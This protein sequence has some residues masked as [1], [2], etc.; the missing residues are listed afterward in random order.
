M[1]LISKTVYLIAFLMATV[2]LTGC[3]DDVL[4]PCEG[5]N[6]ENIE[7]FSLGFTITLPKEDATR[8]DVENYDNYIDTKDKFRVFFFDEYGRFLFGAIDRTVTPLPTID[9]PTSSNW[10]VRV[11]INYIVDRQG[12][13]F[14]VLKIRDFLRKHPFKVAILANWPNASH[15]IEGDGETDDDGNRLPDVVVDVQ[16]EPL[17]NW[18]NSFLNENATD[19]KNINDLHHLVEDGTYSDSSRRPSYEF[20][21]KYDNS[22][23]KWL[24]SQMIN[25]VENRGSFTGENGAEAFLRK[26]W[27][28][29]GNSNKY[30]HYKDLWYLWCFG[31]NLFDNAF[32]EDTNQAQWKTINSNAF[33]SWRSNGLYNLASFTDKNKL[34]FV[35]VNGAITN[36]SGQPWW[37][38]TINDGIILPPAQGYD[39]NSKQNNQ[40]YINEDPNSSKNPAGYFRFRA[41]SQGYLRIKCAT[42]DNSTATIVIQRG[43]NIETT[44]PV[45]STSAIE[46]KTKINIT[47]DSEDVYIW[48]TDDTSGTAIIYSI[49]YI[50][51]IHLSDTDR[52]NKCPSESN[53]IPMYGVQNFNKLGD[54]WSEGSTFDLSSDAT[55]DN[56]NQY[57]GK[58][59]SLIRSL[60]KVEVFIHNDLIKQ[61]GAIND[62]NGHGHVLM[63]CLNRTGRCEPVDVETPTSDLWKEHNS[64]ATSHCEYFD[65]INYG[66]GYGS[67]LSGSGQPQYSNY[68]SWFYGTWGSAKWNVTGSDTDADGNFKNVKA[69]GWNY[70]NK[71]LSIPKNQPFPHLF[72]PHIN[73]SDFAQFLDAGSEG[74][75]RKF[76]FYMPDKGIDDPNTVGD[77]SKTPKVAHIEFRFNSQDDTNLDDNNCYRIYF[78]S[79][80]QGTA[81]RTVAKDGYNT[82]E[83]NRNNLIK[84]WPVMRNHKYQFYVGGSGTSDL[85]VTSKINEWGYG[86]KKE[87]IW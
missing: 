50:C 61:Y 44:I 54:L 16:D 83:K 77:L 70:N 34:N 56:G 66:P 17:W 57:K 20:M 82:Y 72:N 30:R 87:V 13:E 86:G 84:H 12:N 27:V 24:G 21:L 60:A 85:T 23:G 67:S 81:I 26:N 38:P 31:G 2:C 4:Q 3:V 42:S 74:N 14:D 15:T 28:P 35:T 32:T 52:I 36:F 63:R 47:E 25:W 29:H 68:L 59:I 41:P 33:D 45:T 76:V 51:N 64:S 55:G 8:S 73:R 65:I 5:D 40:K 18:E 62:G 79:Y 71:S 6:T 49:E 43:S 7:G 78:T 10:Y 75:Y 37:Y 19:I 11:P 48:V 58:K 53:P 69:S 1:K 9:D 22:T 80:A 39:R 46:T